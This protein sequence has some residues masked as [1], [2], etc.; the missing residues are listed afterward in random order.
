MCI[1]LYL[2]GHDGRAPSRISL[3]TKV[4]YSSS[5]APVAGDQGPGTVICK[6]NADDS[7]SINEIGKRQPLQ[8]KKTFNVSHETLEREL[9]R[10]FVPGG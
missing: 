1:S 7:N 9:G 3:A 10:E 5:T 8:K 2:T 6:I 4:S